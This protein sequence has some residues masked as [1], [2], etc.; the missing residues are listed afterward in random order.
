MNKRY[1]YWKPGVNRHMSGKCNHVTK[2]INIFFILKKFTLFTDTQEF[3]VTILWDVSLNNFFHETVW[4]FCHVF[5]VYVPSSS[6]S[7]FPAVPKSLYYTHVVWLH[8]CYVLPLLWNLHGRHT[9]PLRH[10][11][12]ATVCCV[13]TAAAPYGLWMWSIF[14]NHKYVLNLFITHTCRK[15]TIFISSNK[16]DWRSG[17]SAGGIRRVDDVVF[18]TPF[19]VEINHL[20]VT[21]FVIMLLL[22]TYHRVYRIK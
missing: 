4:W 11:Q 3:K 20:F 13:P 16:W 18:I 12:T 10:M 15:K 19:G 1:V 8:S 6:L 5:L 7:W 9:G 22:T 17:K 21:C 2:L 14:Q